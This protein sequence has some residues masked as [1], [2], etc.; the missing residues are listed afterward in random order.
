MNQNSA[1]APSL[2]RREI[3]VIGY[4]RISCAEQREVDDIQPTEDPMDDRGVVGRIG[5]RDRQRSSE[6][7]TVFRSLHAHA[8]GSAI[9]LRPPEAITSKFTSNGVAC[10]WISEI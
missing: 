6:A 2:G 4:G 9:H 5:N 8:I 1:N 7:D 3:Q 10:T